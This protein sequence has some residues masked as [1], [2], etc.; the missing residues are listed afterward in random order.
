MVTFADQL[1]RDIMQSGGN[2]VADAKYVSI[3]IFKRD[4]GQVNEIAF[5]PCLAH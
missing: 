5:G 3:G 1:F 4:E 2:A